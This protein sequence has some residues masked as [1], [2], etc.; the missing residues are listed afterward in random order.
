MTMGWNAVGA[1]RELKAV[2]LKFEKAVS[3][4][5][6]FKFNSIGKGEKLSRNK[7]L[8]TEEYHHI[9]LFWH[10]FLKEQFFLF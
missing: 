9:K 1:D 10:H 8:V 7:F 6:N 3:E 4:F 5:E 2:F